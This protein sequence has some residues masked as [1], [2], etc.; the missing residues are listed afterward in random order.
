MNDAM[1]PTYRCA[2]ILIVLSLVLSSC[3]GVFPAIPIMEKPQAVLDYP[4]Q[5]MN[6]P[7][8][9]MVNVPENATATPTPFQPIPPTAVFTP[10]IIPT[11]TAFP[12][13]TPPPAIATA[14][15]PAEPI[16]VLENQ[17]TILLLGSDKRPWET[18]F[19]T[20]TII[21]LVLNPTQGTV[22][23]LSFPRDLYV[24]IPGWTQDR[25]NTAFYHGGFKTLAATLQQNFGVKP[26]HYVLINFRSFKQIID[27]LGGLDVNVGQP[28]YD[29]IQGKGWVTIKKGLTNMDADMALWYARSR[30]TTNDFARNRRQQEVLVAMFNKFISLGALKRLPELYKMYKK[31][32]STDLGFTDGLAMLPLV[33]QLVEDTGRIKRYYVSPSVV[34]DYIT[35]GGAMVLMPQEAEIRKIVKQ[36]MNGK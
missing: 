15:L 36:A 2:Y 4:P 23:L 32:I 7:M 18:G 14:M 10:T 26:D 5:S 3:S 20:D 19:R 11:L 13:P 25:I 33:L 31:S 24:Y 30:K 21:L 34:W 29:R 35:P 1:K 17:T 12:T 6:T 27:S 28:L 9:V 16:P 8:P 22:S